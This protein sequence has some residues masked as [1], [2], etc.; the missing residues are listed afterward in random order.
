MRWRRKRTWTPGTPQASAD[1][2]AWA[3]VVDVSRVTD[4]TA[5]MANEYLRSYSRMNWVSRGEIGYRVVDM[6]T[7]EVQ[8]PPPLT[9]MPLDIAATVLTKRCALQPPVETES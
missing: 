7:P 2:E 3:D 1:L 8:P 4:R 6:I 5:A 9:L